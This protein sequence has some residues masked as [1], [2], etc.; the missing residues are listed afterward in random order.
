MERIDRSQWR[1]SAHCDFFGRIEVPFYSVTFRL[2]VTPLV[3]YCKAH[4]L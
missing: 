3:S 4:G 2:D 1:R